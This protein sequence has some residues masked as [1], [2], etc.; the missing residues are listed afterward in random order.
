VKK[1]FILPSLLVVVLAGVYF[2]MNTTTGL[3]L[4]LRALPGDNSTE[5]ATGSLYRGFTLEGL[6][7]SGNSFQ[8]DIDRVTADWRPLSLLR[9]H[10]LLHEVNI[11]GMTVI[12]NDSQAG[13]ESNPTLSLDL[14]VRVSLESLNVSDVVVTDRNAEV[15]FQ[16]TLLFI[17]AHTEDQLLIVDDLS[18]SSPDYE[19]GMSGQ[20]NLSETAEH[21]FS[22]DWL[23][24]E[25]ESL[26][27]IGNTIITGTLASTNIRTNVT[28]PLQASVDL[29][30]E[31]PAGD[32]S[33]SGTASIAD[34]SPSTYAPQFAEQVFRVELSAT[35][36]LNAANLK[37]DVR[38]IDDAN[39]PVGGGP[40][41]RFRNFVMDF[42]LDISEM[43]TG[44][45]E[46]IGSSLWEAI[47]LASV[48][49]GKSVIF[50][51]GRL[52]M[53]YRDGQ[54]QIQSGSGFNYANENTG[55]WSISG[56][57]NAE[58]IEL[59]SITLNYAGGTLNG[60]LTLNR[61]APL[62]VF[63]GSASWTSLGVPGNSAIPLK[64]S[65]GTFE[66]A[67][68]REDY[69]LTTNTEI[70]FEDKPPLNLTMTATG[71][72]EL[73]RIDPVV[74]TGFDG[75]V[76][77]TGTVEWLNGPN[78]SLQLTGTGLNPGRVWYDWPGTLA[79]DASINA[80]KLDT[81]FE[82]NIQDVSIA[83]ILRQ[84]PVQLAVSSRFSPGL[85]QISKAKLSSATSSIDING[86]WGTQT[87]IDWKILSP[88]LNMLHP[89]M[90]GQLNAEGRVSGTPEH[91]VM[92]GVLGASK[93]TSPWVSLEKADA[94]LDISNIAG[95]NI[96][97]DLSLEKL[98]WQTSTQV[99]EVSLVVTG[100]TS[101][102]DFT[103]QASS[104]ARQLLATGRGNYS[105][106]Q[107]Q[108]SIDTLKVVP[109]TSGDTWANK[110]PAKLTVRKDTASLE[111]LCLQNGPAVIC[112]QL[113]RST[114]DSWQAGL[115]ASALPVALLNDYL[116]DDIDLAGLATI[117]ID[118]TNPANDLI[119]G[120][121]KLDI[122]S[123]Q[124]RMHIDTNQME[125][126]PVES[127]V[128][129]FDL[130]DGV[131]T[132]RLLA[133]A[134]DRSIEPLAARLELTGLDSLRPDYTLV[135][136]N[137]S[138]NWKQNDLS[139][140]SRVIPQITD[141]KGDIDMDL[142]IEGTVANPQLQGKLMLANAG[143]IVPELGI[144]LED[145]QVNGNSDSDGSYT[146]NGQA[147]SG[148]G[149]LILAAGIENMA[150]EDY[151][152]TARISGERFEIINA[153]EIRALASPDININVT[154]NSIGV[155][156]TVGISDA[157]INLGE[158]R[159]L[160]TL[161]D[162][163]VIKDALVQNRRDTSRLETAVQINF[164][165]RIDI[166]GQGL[167]GNLTGNLDVYTSARG[168]L[169][170]KGEVAISEGKFSAY[171]QSLV[172]EEGKLIF[173]GNRLNNPELRITAVRRIDDTITVGLR[174][175]GYAT[176]PLLTLFSTPALGDDEILAYIVFGRPIASLTSGEGSDLIGAATAMGLQN[177]GFLTRSLSSTFGLD[178]L[179]FTSDATGENASVIIGKYITP[180]LYLSYM[181][182]V[183]ERIATARIR[184]DLNKNW[185]VE[186]KSST[187]VGVDLYYNIQK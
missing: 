80:Q 62:P 166:Q 108:G 187:D 27:I 115:H 168:E 101:S 89:E 147:A 99:D 95:D 178:S 155:S 149:E 186:V 53:Q 175:T 20:L 127:F 103:L 141:I 121:G 68:T 34:I 129:E 174:I 59:N 69:R 146:L 28:A 111:E 184:Y 169:L 9:G 132:S 22:I 26:D 46:I 67:G 151:V 43:L 75:E 54:F 79:M 94:K 118:V 113:D 144:A 41:Y 15:L 91:P 122:S 98:T 81:G 185:S 136:M 123:G 107:W 92:S 117:D 56:S 112:G 63:N 31:E 181:M 50:D 82:V 124:I 55:D 164:G 173:L 162:D 36:S 24:R 72:R 13:S 45:P 58:L 134:A 7:L 87:G 161:S 76:T 165:E 182:G 78:L 160:V 47:E 60:D 158:F 109:D 126:I 88:D 73:T 159:E 171:G 156:G 163:V 35:G 100:N 5:I 128:L 17:S 30:L 154:H 3:K 167:T 153:P 131:L 16:T 96:N 11:V 25:S 145:I 64:F 14:P 61:A 176:N 18:L 110:E 32:L 120:N 114:S 6:K 74:L 77:G 66:I 86:T 4:L 44:Q 105:D 57:G 85:I 83:G 40:A 21:Q 138:I 170:G 65:A 177:S 23:F 106:T 150:D 139:I 102:H 135:G 157:T 140:L 84:L 1:W 172:I 179:Q 38:L 104:N 119:S 39:T 180:K 52:D 143:F 33:W 125:S 12:L 48:A 183:F 37:G 97:I 130:L 70:T 29:T 49:T 152:L 42:N 137:G 51:E 8:L 116:P 10:L 19:A 71:D 148:G 93:I 90:S 133:V 2:A 142:A